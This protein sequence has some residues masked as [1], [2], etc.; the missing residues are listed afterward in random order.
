MARLTNIS[1]DLIYNMGI[2]SSMHGIPHVTVSSVV[3]CGT[4]VTDG[5]MFR[6]A[7]GQILFQTM[8]NFPHCTDGERPLK[9]MQ[10]NSLNVVQ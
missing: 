4:H 8:S 3:C 2:I 7:E 5:N 1:M 9:Y 10:L 6:S